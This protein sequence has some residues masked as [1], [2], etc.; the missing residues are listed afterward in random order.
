[1]WV[2]LVL[3]MSHLSWVWPEPMPDDVYIYDALRTPRGRGQAA[4][5][6]KPGGSLAEVPPQEL[7]SGLV[8]ALK[9]RCPEFESSLSALNLGCVGQVGAQ[10]GHIALVSRIA[11]G[12]PD[13]VAV[14]SINNYCVSGLTAVANSASAV[15]EG[16]LALAGGVECLS[17]VGFLADQASYYTDPKMIKSLNWVPPIMGAELIASMEGFDKS[18]LDKITLMSHQRAADAWREDAFANC[19]EAVVN[20]QGE[21][22]LA[23]D[24]LVRADISLAGLEKMQ[25]AF[26]VQGEMGFDAMMLKRHPELEQISHVH[27]FANC[28]GMADGA[29]LVLLGDQAAGNNAGLAPK[30]KIVAR[31]ETAG[32]PVL[33]FGA[34]FAAMEQVLD[35]AKLTIHDFDRIEF[36]EAF[37]AVPLKFVRD[38]QPDMD[39]LNVNG[40]HLAMGHPM[41]ATGAIL[42]T[43][44]VHELKRCDGELGLVVALA[45]G[46][47]GSAMIIERAA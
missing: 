21:T 29:A 4:T 8:R 18:D 3:P 14:Q 20:A 23:H 30:A 37:A 41:G 36:M 28:P 44:L 13:A 22:L 25:P 45:G 31:A 19:V 42:L 39:K 40:G 11:A 9:R 35:A 2:V 6:D 16:K 10:G 47:L 27:S 5:D 46:G 24:E 12:L 26:A 15:P 7:V 1:M 38:Y 32:D 33:Q 43:Q 34:G 17:Q